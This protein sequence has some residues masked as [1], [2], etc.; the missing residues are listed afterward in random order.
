M[1]PAEQGDALWIEYGPEARP[2]RVLI[3]G[4]VR[5]TATLIGARIAEL[6]KP[7]RQFDLLIVTHID[8]DHIGGVPKL[9]AN[10]PPGLRFDDVWFNA[11][12]HLQPD[13]LGAVEGEIVSAQLDRSGWNWNAAFDG[14][15]VVVAA[16]GK[17]PR[18]TLRG[19]MTLTLLSPTRERLDVLRTEWKKV[20]EAAG[21]ETGVQDEA[22]A[23]AARR[24]GIPD[25]LGD[26]LDVDELAAAKLV[27]DKAPA[28]GST[29][30]VL[31]EY[32]GLSCLLTGDAHPDVLR[33]GL[34]RLCKER[35]IERL[36]VSALKVPHH[37]QPLQRIE[38][39]ARTDR[40]GSVPVL[41]T[42]TRPGTRISR[43]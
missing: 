26:R 23:E 12:R 27:P 24:R 10:P 3:D 8:S 34:E 15:A 22:L 13:Q 28:N 9:L 16:T 25:L 21:L 19:G 40:D 17:L 33:A 6:P 14:K 20:V 35:H 18:R 11:W 38:R 30:A 43:G 31:A 7:D 41:E 42:A 39:R 2:H 36:R 37:G 1:L 32:E 29:I 5:K 4:G